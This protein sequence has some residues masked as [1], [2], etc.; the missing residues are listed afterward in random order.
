[1][2]SQSPPWYLPVG[3]GTPFSA[4]ETSPVAGLP[5]FLDNAGHSSPRL[6]YGVL[7]K[8][9]QLA[10]AEEFLGH[11]LVAGPDSFAL[12]LY[13]DTIIMS[14]RVLQGE[15]S[16]PGFISSLMR[17]RFRYEKFDNY[18]SDAS[19][20][21]E[22][23]SLENPAH[24][25]KRMQNTQNKSSIVLF[26]PTHPVMTSVLRTMMYQDMVQEVGSVSEWLDPWNTQLYLQDEWGFKLTASTAIFSPISTYQNGKRGTSFE[27]GQIP[28]TSELSYIF[29]HEV[30]NNSTED[31]S[32]ILP[33]QPLAESLIRKAVCFGEGPR[34]YKDNIDATAAE[35]LAR[36]NKPQQ[37]FGPSI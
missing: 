8:I 22:G 24:A 23:L 33:A 25:A 9:S 12:R 16:V 31:S 18:V 10:A 2:T 20:F 17:Y 3:I 35:F 28:S 13:K 21:L 5:N 6:G 27:A 26:G 29:S 19:N 34:F 1:M 15:I 14:L 30:M 37:G 4:S 11:Y 7:G 32:P 36:M